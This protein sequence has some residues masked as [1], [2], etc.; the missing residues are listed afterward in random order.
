MKETFNSILIV[1]MLFTSMNNS[2]F[3]Q[4]SYAATEQLS[5]TFSSEDGTNG[6]AVAWNRSKKLYY[7]VIAGNAD[8]PLET[9]SEDGRMLFSDEASVDARGM[10]FNPKTKKI[11]GNCADDAGYFSMGVSPNGEPT[12]AEITT[13]GQNQPDFNSVG[14]FDAKKKKV[15]FYQDGQINVYK[16]KG[17]S[18]LPSIQLS[19]LPCDITSI[20]MTSVIFT[21]RKGEELGV[22]DYE[23]KRVYLFDLKGNYKAIVSLPADAVTYDMFRFSYANNKIWLYDVDTRTWTGYSF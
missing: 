17:G 11:E 22:L 7:A 21:G 16:A 12:Q 20:N 19:N 9:F 5:L 13:T 6:T 3:A 18:A 23:A 1:S 15:Y 10:W 14:A 4:K 2:A 8:F